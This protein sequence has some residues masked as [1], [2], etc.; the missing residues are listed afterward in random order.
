MAENYKIKKGDTLWDIAKRI[1]GDGRRY[2]ELAEFNNIAN[3]N[4]IVAG[5]TL[6]IPSSEAKS[7]PKKEYTPP[8]SISGDFSLDSAPAREQSYDITPN[9]VKPY[10]S[11]S[12]GVMRKELPM[13]VEEASQT[14]LP[15]NYYKREVVQRPNTK[16]DYRDMSD[17]EEYKNFMA[18]LEAEEEDK[19]Y[20]DNNISNFYDINPIDNGVLDGAT[21]RGIAGKNRNP[22]WN[23]MTP[24]QFDER[25]KEVKA[26]AKSARARK[27]L[28]KKHSSTPSYRLGFGDAGKSH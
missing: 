27:G 11:N 2:K 20:K 12:S 28:Y 8:A 24:A 7:E 5:K 19:Y 14:V 23:I 22:L 15:K 16:S 10:L 4:M 3:P 6:Q 1:Y 21:V 25:V 9:S 13:D 26:N 18:E 17:S